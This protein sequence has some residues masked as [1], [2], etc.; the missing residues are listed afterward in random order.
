VSYAQNAR[1]NEE[2]LLV[3]FSA[4]EESERKRIND[5]LRRKD[6]SI[7]N[8]NNDLKM[9]E[10]VHKDIAPYD[11]LQEASKEYDKAIVRHLIDV[12]NV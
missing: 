2:K 5:G 11:A 4:L 10:F 9:K 1:W 7:E 6:K 12:I 8:E 3:G